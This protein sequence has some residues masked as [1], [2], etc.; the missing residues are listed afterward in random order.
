MADTIGEIIDHR[1]G[2][3]DDSAWNFGEDLPLSARDGRPA[4][5]SLQDPT[6][7]DQPDTTQSSFYDTSD[8]S[9]DDGAVHANDGIGDKT[10][11]L[12][13]QGGTFDGQTITGIDAGDSTLSK[14]GRLYLEMIP[15]LTSGA[16]WAQYGQVLEST[17]A[18]LAAGGTG[19]FTT[20]DCD[21]VDQAVAAT[22]LETPIASAAAQVASTC[23][24]GTTRI[25][26]KQDDD[27]T[28]QTFGFTASALWHRT[29]TDETPNW[30]SSGT[31]S[32]FAWDPIPSIDGTT[33]ATLKSAA[34]VVPTGQSSYLHFHQAY[35]LAWGSG[36]LYEDG[37]RVLAYVKNGSSWTT[38]TLPWVNGPN[39]SFRHTSLRVFGGDS[40][41]Y[42]SSRL[43]LSSLA[44]RTVALVFRLDGDEGQY[45]VGWWV[46][47]L[48]LYSC[49]NSIAAAPVTTLATSGATA[50]TVTWSTP[51]YVGSDPVSGYHV[52]TSTGKSFTLAPT[53]RSLTLSGLNPATS[54]GVHVAALTA[55]GPGASSLAVIFPGAT[56][57]RARRP[58]SR[59]R[60]AFS[61]TAVVVRRGTSTRV[62]GAPVVLQRK[63]GA[64]WRNMAGG[65]TN[66]SGWKSW[67]VTQT[68]ATYY[69]VVTS[70]AHTTWASASGALK[71]GIKK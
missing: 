60:S 68:S 15:R 51:S 26:R 71:V 54:F 61:L 50:A 6:L 44:G 14:T 69:R 32:W 9:D 45:G 33:V 27:T 22:M 18:M 36:G 70:A 64:A 5:R 40:M 10:A 55:G 28:Q 42:G 11:Y 43:D 12:I 20:A 19:G 30:S 37:G 7:Y 65:T 23:P 53:A 57:S 62:A 41:G 29:P 47:D 4:L 67:S 49:A 16:D 63:V 46:D 31:S 24:S 1:N 34:F 13:S 25:L 8:V 38:V 3:D 21:S 48:Q 2:S 58:R 59:S 52:T 17:C 35:V 39:R 66:S 56:P